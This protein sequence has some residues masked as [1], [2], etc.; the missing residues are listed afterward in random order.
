MNSDR[1]DSGSLGA[2]K[3]PM[4]RCAQRVLWAIGCVFVLPAA[5]GLVGCRAHPSTASE[6]QRIFWE[7]FIEWDW[8]VAMLGL[9]GASTVWGWPVIWGAAKSMGWFWTCGLLLMLGLG[10][11]LA[12]HF[13]IGLG[14]HLSH[15]KLQWHTP[16][17]A[18]Q[19][20]GYML[21]SFGVSGLILLTCRPWRFLRYGSKLRA[22]AAL[23]AV[24]LANYLVAARILMWSCETWVQ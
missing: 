22:L 9:M 14:I 2:T 4:G 24:L 19:T 23:V 1:P 13:L 15:A 16:E 8:L 18:W 20:F 10:D 7:V 17:Y 6:N 3:E 5:L 21:K 12:V 11:V